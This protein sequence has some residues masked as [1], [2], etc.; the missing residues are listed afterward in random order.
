MIERLFANACDGVR[1]GYAG[2]T[3]VVKKR[4][5]AYACDGVRD[6]ITTRFFFWKKNKNRY[7]WIDRRRGKLVEFEEGKG[8]SQWGTQQT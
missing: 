6:C 7:S 2:E 3:G 8:V 5:I 1:D 4:I